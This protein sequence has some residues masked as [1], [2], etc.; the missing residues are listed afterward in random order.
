MSRV[1]FPQAIVLFFPVAS[2]NSAPPISL[3]RSIRPS[4]VSLF[5][6][7]RITTLVSS[8]STESDK[9]VCDGEL[10][11]TKF[12]KVASVY[13]IESTGGSKTTGTV[14]KRPCTMLE[15]NALKSSL[16]QGGE[17]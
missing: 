5:K 3:M 15:P 10:L 7:L 9:N 13:I 11:Q 6:D 14:T 8:L 2:E 12:K 1:H 4:C 17:G 16:K